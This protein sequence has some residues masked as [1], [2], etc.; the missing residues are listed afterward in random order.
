MTDSLQ[1]W[2]AG[3]RQALDDILPILYDELSR[4]ASS[5]LRRER[6]EHTLQTSALVHEA[7]LRLIDQN[8]VKWRDRSH[9]F[10]IAAQAMRRV[11]VDHARSR[12]SSKR[13]GGAMLLA[14][15]ETLVVDRDGDPAVLAL[16][17]ALVE[18]MKLDAELARVVELRFFGGLDNPE[19]AHVE[20]VSERTVIRR[21]RTAQ[22]WLFRHLGNGGARS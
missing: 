21:W 16:D 12:G 18:L 8:R 20:Q 10:A 6:R 4:I 5:Y 14:L 3:D 22:A 17:A 13:G 1:R 19:I 2:S 15:D 11:L 9:F 7:Y